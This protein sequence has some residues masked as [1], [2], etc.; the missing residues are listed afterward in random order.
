MRVLGCA[1]ERRRERFLDRAVGVAERAR[2]LAQNGVGDDHRRELA[3]GDLIDSASKNDLPAYAREIIR[4]FATRAYR[5]PITAAEESALMAVFRKS[6]AAGRNFQ[7]SVK[8]ALQ[9][10]L[11]SP[12][13]LFLIENEQHART[14]AARR[15]RTG[16]QAVVLPV[17]RAAGS[18]DIEVGRKWRA[19]K[20]LDAEVGRMIDDPR[21]SRFVSEFTS[22][23]LSL[24]KFHVLEPDRKRFPKLT[25]DTRTQLR[26][27]PVQFLQYLIRNNLPVRNL[28]AVRFHGRE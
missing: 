27:E 16:F 14:G 17:E 25:R 7:E 11:T 8:D 3:P 9:V 26:Q 22:Q 6:F 2:Q 1:L 18:H 13:F 20:Q 12:Q 21:F 24:D 15:L 28:I 10:V 5:R 4:K 23:W 19:P